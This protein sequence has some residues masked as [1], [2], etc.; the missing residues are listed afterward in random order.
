VE[1]R[2]VRLDAFCTPSFFNALHELA[3]ERGHA[4]HPCGLVGQA[5]PLNIYR[6]WCWRCNTAVVEIE[7]PRKAQASGTVTA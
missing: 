4:D 3:A 5:E 6:W 7:V 2:V 1:R